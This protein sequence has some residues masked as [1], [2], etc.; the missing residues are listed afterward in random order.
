MLIQVA[1]GK[2]E[3]KKQ[4]GRQFLEVGGG[5][6]EAEV[7]ELE[8]SNS[9]SDERTPSCSPEKNQ[10][11]GKSSEMGREEDSDSQGPNSNK[12]QKLNHPSSNSMD[13]TQTLSTEATMRKA[14][15][16]VRAR[17]E[18]PMVRVCNRVSYYYY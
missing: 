9:S 18:A 7:D 1:G 5:S 6:G 14:R 4:G 3:E 8:V 11:N 12:L 15:V 16:S 10:N 17:S 2:A 13:Q